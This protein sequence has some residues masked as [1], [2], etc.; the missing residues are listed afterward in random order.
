ME[1]E[2]V[3]AAATAGLAGAAIEKPTGRAGARHTRCTDCGAELVGR[4][5]HQCGQPAHLHR[6]LLHLGEELLHGVMHF[7]GRIWRTLPLLLFRPG[8]LTREWVHGKRARYVSPL[9]MFLFTVFLTFMVLSL[10]PKSDSQDLADVTVKATADLAEERAGLARA[11][12]ALAGVDPARR[13]EA[14][15]QVA[16]ARQDLR[17]AEKLVEAL[18]RVQAEGGSMTETREA[19]KA[20]GKTGK[21]EVNLGSER[22]NK[23]VEHAAENP[24]LAWYK[25]KNSFYKFSFLLVPLSVPFVALLF[26]WKRGFTLYDHAVFVL[27]SLTFVSLLILVSVLL[28]RM[29]ELAGAIATGVFPFLVP[30]HM[31]HQ[32][33]GA[34][35]LRAFSA[36]WRLF[37]LLIFCSIVCV[38][39]VVAVALLGLT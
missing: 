23:A 17:K 29:S 6:S 38:I 19:L 2:S 22:L 31:Y 25:F 13:V 18:N 24:E 33:K 12:R 26:L 7:D 1:L 28:A 3:G 14:E 27:Y 34:Y 21:V 16:E 8:R 10:L 4:F 30:T 11:E 36:L 20:G 15:A 35:G 37:V 5:C 39:F 32:L 9:A